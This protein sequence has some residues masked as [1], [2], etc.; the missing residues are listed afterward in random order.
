VATSTNQYRG[1]RANSRLDR[2]PLLLGGFAAHGPSAA[3]NCNKIATPENG[4]P[5]V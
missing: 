2:P 4:D 3:A 1:V 5:V